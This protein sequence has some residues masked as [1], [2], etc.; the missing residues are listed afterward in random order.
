MTELTFQPVRSLARLFL[1]EP[2]HRFFIVAGP[3]GSTKTTSCIFWLLTQAAL[4]YPSPDGVR[5]TRFAI[6]RNTLASIKQTVLKDVRSLLGGMAEW[7]PSSNTV[8][9]KA[10]DI[11]SEWLLMPLESPEDQRRLLSLQLSGIYINELREVDWALAMAGFSRTGRF[12]SEKHGGVACRR[13]FLLADSNMGVEGSDMH[14]FLEVEGPGNP[15]LLYVRQPS[16]LS[17]EA[18][19]LQFLPEGYYADAMVGATPSWIQQHIHAEWGLD[20][21]GEPVWAGAWVPQL[22][23]AECYLEPAP[24]A[25]LLIGIDPGLNPAAAVTQSWN[26]QLRVL[27][28]LSVPNIQFRAFLSDFLIPLLQQPRFWQRQVQCVMDPAGR[29]THMLTRDTALGVVREH[30][31]ACEVARTNDLDPRLQA[32]SRLLMGR[33]DDGEPALLVDPRCSELI[34]GFNGAYRYVRDSRQE[35][36]AQ[37]EKKHPISDLQDALQYAVLGLAVPRVA[38]ALGMERGRTSWASARGLGRAIAT[39][40]PVSPKGWT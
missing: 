9:I 23:I 34:R 37:P 30:G 33:T 28:E 2:F 12:P 35:L 32:V 16:A 20:L 3:I 17:E 10:G 1:P 6:V 25:P 8:F 22:H 15:R 18:D 14:R 24:M 29:S 27:A 19:W 26:G 4:Q 11:D 36:K 38:N 31:L 40:A 13:R 39:A 5:R 7:Q 21:S